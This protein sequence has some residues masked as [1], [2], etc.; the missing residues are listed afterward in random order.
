MICGLLKNT[1]DISLIDSAYDFR[2]I[3]ITNDISLIDFAYTLILGILKYN[4]QL[5]SLYNYMPS[6][7]NNI[8]TN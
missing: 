4:K 8:K 2:L 7:L 3:K 5:K 6:L 1:Y